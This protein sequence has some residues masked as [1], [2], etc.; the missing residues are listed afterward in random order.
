[1]GAQDRLVWNSSKHGLYTV[2]SGYKVVKVCKDEAKGE[3]GTSIR[4][5]VEDRTLW[6]GIWKMNI[7]KKIQHF[8]WRVCHN[9]L[10]VMSNLRKRGREGDDMCLFCGEGRETTEHLFFHCAKS[11]VI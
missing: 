11:K 5:A 6:T 3:E 9:K 7:K 8:I 10:P 1:M 4:R 2:S